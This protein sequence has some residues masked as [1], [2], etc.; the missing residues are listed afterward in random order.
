MLVNILFGHA[1]IHHAGYGLLTRRQMALNTMSL[2]W[3]G[4]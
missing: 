1:V 4:G 3:R 2:Q